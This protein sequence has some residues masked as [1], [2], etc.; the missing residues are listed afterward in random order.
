MVAPSPLPSF[1]RA[2]LVVLLGIAPA[3]IEAAVIERSIQDGTTNP[4][5]LERALELFGLSESLAAVQAPQAAPV[6]TAY[7]RIA[8]ISI[9]LY[10]Y[11]ETRF[12]VQ[13]NSHVYLI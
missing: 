12:A 2:F 4:S 11:A 13:Q 5:N 1:T 9:A 3:L 8:S 6:W 10:E 7:L